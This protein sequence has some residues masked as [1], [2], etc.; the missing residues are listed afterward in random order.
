M[1]EESRPPIHFRRRGR[2]GRV[3]APRR[4][5]R[6]VSVQEEEGRGVRQRR[7]RADLDGTGRDRLGDRPRDERRVQR[8]QS[9]ARPGDAD[10]HPHLH[11]VRQRPRR[12]AGTKAQAGRARRRLRAGASPGQH[13]GARSEEQG[14]R[15]HRERRHAHGRSD[16]AVRDRQEDALLR[17]LHR[18]RAAAR[19]PTESVRLQ[20]PRE[21]RPGNGEHRSLSARGPAAP[22][23][24]DRRVRAGGR[25]RR[26][27]LRGRRQGAAQARAGRRRRSCGSAMRATPSRSAPPSQ[28]SSSVP[29]C[30]PW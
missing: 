1:E 21:L 22:A 28:R 11:R 4:S 23:G 30:A 2:C 17:S 16:H 27:G 6:R 15:V 12:R 5:V 8:T 10:G 13:G 14:V 24:G 20:L 26:L 3:A 9:R 29:T 19:R 7:G 25:L 18:H